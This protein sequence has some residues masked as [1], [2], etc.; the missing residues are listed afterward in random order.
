MESENLQ[1]LY[2]PK[3][4]VICTKLKLNFTVKECGALSVRLLVRLYGQFKNIPAQYLCFSF[5]SITL[6]PINPSVNSHGWDDCSLI[7]HS[8]KLAGCSVGGLQMCDLHDSLRIPL[9]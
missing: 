7:W 9:G 1:V 3:N 6:F 8:G 4:F 2:F 5:A